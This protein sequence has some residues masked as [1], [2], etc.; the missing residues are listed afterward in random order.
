MGIRL[1]VTAQDGDTAAAWHYFEG[2]VISVGC[3]KDAALR[4]IGAQ[5]AA[6][7]AIVIMV[8]GGSPLLIT[9]ALGTLLNGEPLARATQRPLA[10][11]DRIQIGPYLIECR[12][13]ESKS[14]LPVRAADDASGRKPSFEQILN[15]LRTEDDNFY[16]SIEGGGR[17]IIEETMT[18]KLLGWSSGA[19]LIT[20]D[21][22]Q[23]DTSCAVVRKDWSGVSIEPNGVGV[24]VNGERIS[25]ARGLRHGDRVTCAAPAKEN[26]P[27]KRAHLVFHEPASLAILEN[28]LRGEE[29]PTP[30]TTITTDVATTDAAALITPPSIS[31]S[32]TKEYFGAFTLCELMLMALGTLV[33]AA[34]IFLLLGWS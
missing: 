20:L 28:I 29:L 22:T 8:E 6:E 27:A 33:G 21:A 14:E 13:R 25:G 34:L 23:L 4:L 1:R 19:Q 24:S 15:K 31:T 3:D 5:I 17:L 7:Q 16:F 2:P 30:V 32:A 11:E 9:R 26:S 18:R 10:D 12:L